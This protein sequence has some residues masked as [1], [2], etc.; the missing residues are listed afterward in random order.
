MQRERAEVASKFAHTLAALVTKAEG[1][2][3]HSLGYLIRAAEAE[4][5]SEGGK[6]AP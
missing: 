5:N 3:L 6:A 1:S 4:A 2:D